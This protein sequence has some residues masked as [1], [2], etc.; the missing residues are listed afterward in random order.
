MKVDSLSKIKQKRM[1]LVV[2]R[3]CC[4]FINMFL[5]LQLWF[6]ALKFSSPVLSTGKGRL[7]FLAPNTPK[8]F[9]QTKKILLFPKYML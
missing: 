1:V 5:V 6:A 4:L 7:P 8:C 3:D 2:K 9:C